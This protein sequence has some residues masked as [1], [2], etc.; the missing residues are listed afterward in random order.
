MSGDMAGNNDVATGALPRHRLARLLPEGPES[1]LL[2]AAAL[3]PHCRPDAPLPYPPDPAAL[4]ALAE[5]H[6]MAPPLHALL[7]ARGTH[8]AGT[9]LRD[10]RRR[11]GVRAMRQAAAVRRVT[12]A[13]ADAGIDVLVLKGIALS[14]LLYGAPDLRPAVDIDLLVARERA[15]DA[16]RVLE[17]LGYRLSSVMTVEEL[18]ALTKDAIYHGD[19]G[20]I[21]L[22]WRPMRNRLLLPWDFAAL[23]AE[24]ITVRPFGIEVHTLAPARYAVFLTVHGVHHGWERLRWLADVALLLRDPGDVDAALA[25]A[26]QDGSA[27]ALLHALALAHAELDAPFADRHREAWLADRRAATIDRVVATWT[28]ARR[29][30]SRLPVWVREQFMLRQADLLLCPDLRS[31]IE[32]VRIL[33]RSPTDRTLFRLPAGLAFLYPLLRPVLLAVRLLR[34]D[35]QRR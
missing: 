29:S 4:L 34:G 32:E 1:D 20:T 23:W 12:G 19:G 30:P 35:Q 2:R 7:S 15:L 8:P 31:R 21:E 22:Q 10:A 17:T 11:A 6:G 18:L 24:R 3:W 28:R 9:P 33:F 13:L 26:E 25:Q 14:Q 5:R 16:H 27:P